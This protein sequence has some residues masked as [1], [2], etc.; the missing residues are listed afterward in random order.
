MS[1]RRRG[2]RGINFAVSIY[3]ESDDEVAPPPPSYMSGME[4]R[5]KSV[6]AESYEPGDDDAAVEKVISCSQ[7][8]PWNENEVPLKRLLSVISKICHTSVF[9]ALIKEAFCT[10]RFLY[11]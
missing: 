4:R 10:P 1:G 11:M 5:R 6:F 2:W 8:Y 3:P 7:S 9:K